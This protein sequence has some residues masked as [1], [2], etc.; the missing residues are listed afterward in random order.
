M[1]ALIEALRRT[2]PRRARSSPRKAS[3]SKPSGPFY[4]DNTELRAKAVALIKKEVPS[5]VGVSIIAV[6]AG[7]MGGV[8][9]NL[10]SFKSFTSE[11]VEIVYWNVIFSNGS[12][13]P[14]IEELPASRIPQRLRS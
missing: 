7:T 12:S 2:L 1:K 6:N 4:T 14:W 8:Q 9:Y 11:M 3:S 5:H 10:E 13:K